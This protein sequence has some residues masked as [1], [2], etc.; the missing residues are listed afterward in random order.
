MSLQLLHER[1]SILLSVAP[2]LLRARGELLV[3]DSVREE[4]RAE[5]V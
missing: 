1:I 3:R 2:Q 4:S 5:T